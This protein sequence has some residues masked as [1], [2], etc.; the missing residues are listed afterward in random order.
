MGKLTNCEGCGASIN[1]TKFK[2]D[3]C[4]RFLHNEN[5]IVKKTST[6]TPQ[7][8]TPLT[9]AMISAIAVTPIM[10]GLMYSL[11]KYKK[12]KKKRKSSFLSLHF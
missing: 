2:C 4:G 6:S 11:S 8:S 3:Y 9:S 5:F 12:Y 1:P 10:V 7:T